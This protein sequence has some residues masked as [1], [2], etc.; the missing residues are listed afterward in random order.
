MGSQCQEKIQAN[1]WPPVSTCSPLP[2][3]HLEIASQERKPA[4][5]KY[6]LCI[7]S[8]CTLLWSFHMIARI[9]VWFLCLE[10]LSKLSCFIYLR[11]CVFY[12]LRKFKPTN[13]IKVPNE[14]NFCE[15][16]F[17]STAFSSL[18]VPNILESLPRNV[19]LL[20]TLWFFVHVL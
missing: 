10:F 18:V 9:V 4:R 2:W 11:V 16:V 5:G 14:F 7:N 1:L 20:W 8:T 17:R 13:T 19:N 3:T 15:H 6:M 12:N